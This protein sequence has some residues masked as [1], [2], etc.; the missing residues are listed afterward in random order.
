MSAYKTIVFEKEAGIGRITL[1]RPEALNVF[2]R[3]M[4]DDLF[5]VMAAIEVDAEIRVVILRGAGKKAF[6]AGADLSEFLTAPA[7]TAARKIRFERDLWGLMIRLR[8]PLIASLH[9][10]VLGSGL[11]MALCCDLRLCTPETR[12]GLPE[13]GLGLIPAAGGTQTLPRIIGPAH[14]LEMLLSTED[15][16]TAV[17]AHRIGLVNRLV[18]DDERE[19]VTR[20]LARKL[21]D[22]DPTAVQQAKQA[23]LRGLSLSLSDGL[24]LEKRLALRRHSDQATLL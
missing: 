11:E 10:Y 8:Q 15:W 5:Q 13:M 21:A 19:E 1:N 6:C 23:I 14:S 16:L 22:F 20:Q 9:G 3:Q 4:R 17:R 7:P 2:N 18:G 12:F 24:K